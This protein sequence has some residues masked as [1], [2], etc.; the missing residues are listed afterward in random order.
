MEAFTIEVPS[1]LDAALAAAL[2]PGA[3]FIAG[4]TT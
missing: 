3:K 4:G 1:D 2:Q